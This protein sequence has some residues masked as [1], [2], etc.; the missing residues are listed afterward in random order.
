MTAISPHITGMRPRRPHSLARLAG[1]LVR[2]AVELAKAGDVPMLKFLLGRVLPRERMIKLNLPPMD[3]ADDGVAALGQI[4]R[5][6]SE[7]EITPADCLEWGGHTFPLL[8]APTGVFAKEDLNNRDR[9][10]PHHC[11]SEKA[12]NNG[13]HDHAEDQA[14]KARPVGVAQE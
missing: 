7:G 5:K 14:N 10:P 6:V 1:K 2:K 12:R 13:L 8:R 11:W 3:F 4:V 9:L